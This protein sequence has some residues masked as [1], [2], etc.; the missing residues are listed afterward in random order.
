[1]NLKEYILQ[2]WTDYRFNREF[3]ITGYRKRLSRLLENNTVLEQEIRPILSKD[4]LSR[5]LVFQWVNK[6]PYQGFLA[7][8]IWG[9]I[10]SATT[11]KRTVSNVE[12]AF[13]ISKT[14]IEKILTGVKELLLNRKEEEAFDYLEKGA[15]KIDGIG[16]SYLTKILYFFSPNRDEESLIFDR[17]GRFMHAAMIIDDQNCNLSTYYNYRYKPN[18]KSELV[19]LKPE[20]E[21][22]ID[23]LSRMRKL[24]KSIEAIQS[25]GHLEAFLFGEKL[26][27]K[28]QNTL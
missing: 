6:N 5:E 14:D 20:K 2:H 18:Y 12:R 8:M 17:W 3:L 10:S 27:K 21:L 25:P 22:Y 28:Y 19:P 24:A 7:G 13:S 23:Y 11:R 26:Y 9:G 16:I 15:G 4:R 1:M